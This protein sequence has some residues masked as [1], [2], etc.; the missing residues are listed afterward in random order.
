MPPTR[1][2]LARWQGTVAALS[3]VTCNMM[4]LED[5]DHMVMITSW[6]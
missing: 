4:A 6:R 3:G 1:A 5:D 2:E